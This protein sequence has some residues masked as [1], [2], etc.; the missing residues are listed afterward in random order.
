MLNFTGIFNQKAW[1][2]RLSSFPHVVAH[3]VFVPRFYA[4]LAGQVRQIMNRGLSEV[5][6]PDRISK[7]IFGYNSYGMWLGHSDTEPTGVFLSPEWRDP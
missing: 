2:H 1:F 7:N 3:D 5:P 6:A 4:A